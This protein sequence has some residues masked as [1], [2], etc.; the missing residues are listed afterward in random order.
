M[1]SEL[2]DVSRRVMQLEIEEA[3]LKNEK[4]KASKD[5]L[6]TLRKELADQEGRGKHS[7]RSV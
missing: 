7:P 6:E 2:D 3:A 1:P 4:H 5:R